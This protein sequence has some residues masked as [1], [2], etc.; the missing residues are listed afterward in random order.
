MA[1]DAQALLKTQHV[2]IF[3]TR[4]LPLMERQDFH[5]FKE[6]W[7]D[8]FKRHC[9]LRSFS[10]L[11]ATFQYHFIVPTGGRN[12]A[13]DLALLQIYERLPSFGRLHFAGVYPEYV[14]LLFEKL[15]TFFIRPRVWQ[16]R[17]CIGRQGTCF[18]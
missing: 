16:C 5:L 14:R 13:R 1:T 11:L 17:H 4:I 12:H 18:A 7:T 10:T 9:A 15:T 6:E 8:L 3:L 2:V